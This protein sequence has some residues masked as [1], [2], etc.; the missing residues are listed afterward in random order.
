MKKKKLITALAIAA[1]L[2]IPIS[3]FAA[4]SDTTVA[5]RVRGF[6]GI[7]TTKLTDTQKADVTSYKQ[8]M[9][10]LQKEFINKMVSNGSIT[11][12]QGDIEIAKIDE[13]LKNGESAYIPGFGG[14]KGDF[15]G[16][17]QKNSFG[18]YGFDVSKLTDAQKADLTAAVKNI[19]ELQKDLVSK[20]VSNTLM[21]KDQG[22]SATKEIDNSL[23]DIQ[24]NGFSKGM[25]L[26][27]GFGC[28]EVLRGIDTTKLTDAQKA[29]FTDFNTKLIA[30]QKELITKMVANGALTQEQGTAAAARIDEMSKL[31][32]ENGTQMK[33]GGMGKGHS[34]DRGGMQ[35]KGL[36]RANPS[37]NSN[38]SITESSVG[39][40]T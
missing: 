38:G 14:G 21:T 32:A 22:D 40:T 34:G 9:A 5:K 27:D 20:A 24:K 6:L 12:E 13:A 16:R 19:A 3:V 2:T 15:D 17:G 37:G 39:P 30:S 35:G 7:D 29:I 4:T 8:K 1:A 28:Y 11:K 36:Q 26:L 18:M 25:K 31:Q 10:E 23:T 33:R